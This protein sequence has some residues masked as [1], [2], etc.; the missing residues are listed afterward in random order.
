MSQN[1]FWSSISVVTALA[2]IA[3]PTFACGFFDPPPMDMPPDPPPT[4]IKFSSENPGAALFG[5]QLNG[6][7]APS[8]ATDCGCG[9]ALFDKTNPQ[10]SILASIPSFDVSDV[11][12]AITNTKTNESIEL[13]DM[14]GNPIFAMERDTS[15]D[16]GLANN[17]FTPD[18]SIGYSAISNNADNWFGFRANVEAFTPPTLGDNEVFTMLFDIDFD[19]EVREA[20]LGLG[21]QFASGGISDPLDP[22]HPVTY[23]GEAMVMENH[24]IPEPSSI[25]SLLALATL[26]A[27]STL[28]RKLKTSKYAGKELEKIS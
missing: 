26:G 3:E 8:T 6:L 24:K 25:F 2:F 18:S 19:P 15:L 27:T 20:L 14:G 28:K 21:L 5:V 17:E 16:N 13:V 11:T 23:S 4:W 9:L 12:F 7:F 22:E 1:R 10:Q